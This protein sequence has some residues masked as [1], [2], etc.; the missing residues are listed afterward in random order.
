MTA[1]SYLFVYSFNIM[2]MQ[3]PIAPIRVTPDPV[4]VLYYG[5]DDTIEQV[6]YI[7]CCN[8]RVPKLYE[9]WDLNAQRVREVHPFA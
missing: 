5:S 3:H 4:I 1:V 7:V 2:R 8:G 9:L 6:P